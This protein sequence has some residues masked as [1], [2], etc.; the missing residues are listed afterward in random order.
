[1]STRGLYG[2]IENEKYIAQY[3]H[4][5]SYPSYL[6]SSFYIACKKNDFTEYNMTPQILE[7]SILFIK[8]SLFC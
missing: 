5:D 6:G 1:M 8:D 7:D 2:F 3:S 4:S